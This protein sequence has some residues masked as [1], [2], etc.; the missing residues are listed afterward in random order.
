MTA[1]GLSKD[2]L[3][4]PWGCGFGSYLSIFLMSG[5]P[6]GAGNSCHK[7]LTLGP[8]APCPLSVFL[9]DHKVRKEGAKV[10]IPLAAAAWVCPV[11]GPQPPPAVTKLLCLESEPVPLGQEGTR[12]R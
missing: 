11:S 4:T 8:P 9:G 10:V 1:Q 3:V 7:S 6:R 12:T 5:W 2:L